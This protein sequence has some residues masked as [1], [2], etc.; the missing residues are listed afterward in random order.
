MI[1]NQLVDVTRPEVIDINA[2]ITGGGLTGQAGA[3]RHGIARALNNVDAEVLHSLE[4]SRLSDRS[5]WSNV[6]NTVAPVPANASS[7]PSDENKFSM[8]HSTFGENHQLVI[9]L[10]AVPSFQLSSQFVL[11]KNTSVK[12][13]L[14]REF[15]PYQNIHKL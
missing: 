13:L 7:S 12:K 10:F 9:L 4:K 3:L 14:D 1:V 15:F 6:R 8:S 2:T 11:R 5:T